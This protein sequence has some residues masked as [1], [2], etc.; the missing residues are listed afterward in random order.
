MLDVGYWTREQIPCKKLWSLCGISV[1]LHRNVVKLFKLSIFSAYLILG[2]IAS[3][4]LFYWV[5]D[6]NWAM[7]YYMEENFATCEIARTK[8]DADFKRG[9]YHLVT[10]GMP[11]ASDRA[12]IMES[13]LKTHFGVKLIFSGC[14]GTP[15]MRCYSLAMVDFLEQKYGCHFREQVVNLADKEYLAK[16]PHSLPYHFT[17]H[18]FLNY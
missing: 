4:N 13:V 7:V 14:T 5:P 12:D 2:L 6:R 15:E 1:I 11:H 18:N 17:E 10:G 3:L 8:A 16:L 9:N